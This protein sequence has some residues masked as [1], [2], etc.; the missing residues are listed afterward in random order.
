[1]KIRFETKSGSVYALDSEAKTWQRESKTGESGEIRTES[2]KIIGLF[3]EVKLNYPVVIFTDPAAD[4]PEFADRY[5]RTSFVTKILSVKEA[6]SAVA[7]TK[8]VE[9][10]VAEIFES[11][12]SAQ[13]KAAVVGMMKKMG[14]DEV[15]GSGESVELTADTEIVIFSAPNGDF[16]LTLERE[17]ELAPEKPAPD[18]ENP[19]LQA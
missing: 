16:I 18:T 9:K 8:Q 13:I 11:I 15:R 3:P 12:R 2:G 10:D 19:A 5:L 6:E 4:T 1:M 17:E 14:V 7:I